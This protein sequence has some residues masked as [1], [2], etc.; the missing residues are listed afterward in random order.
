MSTTHNRIYKRPDSMRYTPTADY[1]REIRREKS[2]VWIKA[3]IQEKVKLVTMRY[4]WY[5]DRELLPQQN[6]GRQLRVSP[7]LWL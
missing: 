1:D 3:P 2:D 7:S 6:A 5:S 4:T